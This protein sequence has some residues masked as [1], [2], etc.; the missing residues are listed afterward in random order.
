MYVGKKL[1]NLRLSLDLNQTEMAAS[2]NLSQSYYSAVEIG[3][4][5][6]SKKM[7]QKIQEKYKIDG[8]YFSANNIDFLN[9]K[10][11]GYFGGSNVGAVLKKT[12]SNEDNN[13]EDLEIEK[14]LNIGKHKEAD[15]QNRW[16]VIRKEKK[17]NELLFLELSSENSELIE[18]YT[19]IKAVMDFE[20][21]LEN[22]EKSKV[23]E[24]MALFETHYTYHD[25]NV[26][27]PTYKEYKRIRETE[28]SKL[29][30]YKPIFQKLS[31]AIRLFQKEM[32]KIGKEINYEDDLMITEDK[33]TSTDE[34]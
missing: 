21:T 14:L 22:I 32:Q 26:I 11:G 1:K 13:Y 25:F 15:R 29:L 24:I 20:F 10:L 12:L 8:G 18:L 34:T 28:L 30:P 9:K 23:F 33:F 27:S 2:L 7:I 5:E 31:D 16:D 4:R 17:Y 19:V 6:I 3:K